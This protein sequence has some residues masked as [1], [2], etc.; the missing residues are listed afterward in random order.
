MFYNRNIPGFDGKYSGSFPSAGYNYITGNGTP[1]VR[2]LF[3]MTAL[4]AAGTPQTP[5]NP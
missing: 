1:K 3:G 4:P 2:S 5:S